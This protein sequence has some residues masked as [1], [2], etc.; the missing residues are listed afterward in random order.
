MGTT[1]QNTYTIKNML[2]SIIHIPFLEISTCMYMRMC[3]HTCKHTTHTHTHRHMHKHR[4]LINAKLSTIL[5]NSYE[6][7]CMYTHTHTH[8]LYIYT[9]T[10][11]CTHKRARTH[12][13]THTRIKDGAREQQK[14]AHFGYELLGHCRL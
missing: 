2:R 13:H 3:Q 6:W 5:F 1:P 7:L 14:D 8:T 4:E 12:A 9:H 10:R 11:A